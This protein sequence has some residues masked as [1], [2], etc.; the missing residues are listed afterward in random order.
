MFLNFYFLLE[1]YDR[2]GQHLYGEEWDHHEIFKPAMRSP[3]DIDAERAPLERQYA[4]AQAEI[5]RCDREIKATLSGSR[6]EQLKAEKAWQFELRNEAAQA[7]SEKLEIDDRYRQR[8]RQFE[9][10]Y[11]TEETLVAA[12]K[13]RDLE[14]VFNA[15]MVIEPELW[16][17]RPGFQYWILE[18]L[19]RVPSNF[20]SR[21]RAPVFLKRDE[22]DA[23]LQR[24]TPI[25]ATAPSDDP[26]SCGRR[27]LDAAV[28]EGGQRKQYPKGEYR[29]QAQ[30]ACPGLSRRAFDRLWDQMVPDSWREG[31]RIKRR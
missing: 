7:L 30:E 23:W 11:R 24:V 21:R 3:E 20:S 17:G 15:G 13:N 28:R 6:V 1:A 19:A 5:E 2:L 16:D 26:E 25:N 29:R 12:L 27:F 4:A 9:R 22:F 18:S 10:R 8:Y 14:A 31:G